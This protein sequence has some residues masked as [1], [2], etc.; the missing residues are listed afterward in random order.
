MSKKPIITIA[1]LSLILAACSGGD[2]SS[3]SSDGNFTQYDAGTHTVNGLTFTIPGQA[4][5]EVGADGTVTTDPA[6][7][8]EAPGEAAPYQ[9]ASGNEQFYFV[10]TDRFANG[11]TSNDFGGYDGDP[12]LSGFD[13]ANEGFYLGGDIRGLTDN[14]D[15]IEGLGTTAI[16]LTPPFK[17]KPVQGEGD[18][19]SAGYHGY[20][21]TDFTQIDPHYGTNDELQAFIDEAHSRD[22]KI[23]FDIITNHTADVITYEGGVFDYVPTTVEPYVDASGAEINTYELAGQEFP[24]LDPATSFPY[25]PVI[26]AEKVPGENTKVPDW[27]NDVTLYHNRGN[28]TWAGESVTYGDFDGL[29]DLMTENKVVVDG[30]AEIYQSWTDMGIDGFRI[31]TAKHVNFEF[32]ES[33]TKQIRDHAGGD[34]FMFGEVFDTN[35]SELARYPRNSDMDSV[36]DFAYQ[37][38]VVSYAN[39]G[40]AAGLSQLFADD[41]RYTT[42]D[43]SAGDLPTFLGNH[44]MGRAGYLLQGGQDVE[45]KFEL[46]YALLYLTRGQPVVY[47]GDEQGFVGSGGDKIARQPLFETDVVAYQDQKLLDGSTFGT[48]AHMSTN[49][50]EYALIVELSALRASHPALSDGPQVELLSS[51]DV[52][53]FSRI[54]PETQSEY[55][56]VVNSGAAADV[57]IPVLSD[58]GEASLL[59]STQSSATAPAS[60][61][62]PS[63]SIESS[64]I[65]VSAPALSA[66][67]YQTDGLV[68][69]TSAA[70]HIDALPSDEGM[71]DVRVEMERGYSEVAIYAH[72]V[73]TDEWQLLGSDVG[74]KARVFHDTSALP[75]D[76]I[77]EYAAVPKGGDVITATYVGGAEHP[78]ADAFDPTL[79]W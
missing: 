76:S 58:D 45:Q 18:A 78:V 10:M 42:A 12:R 75:A 38:A 43:S 74:P 60:S 37:A 46:A 36:L 79:S 2:T 7:S 22:I 73:G 35:V 29:D 26:G 25:V 33:F 51:G 65:A 31:D 48:G 34:F 52:Y 49:T 11:D 53:A 4:S 67:V 5:L 40:S 41:D 8:P 69:A 19:V 15:Y 44:D 77:I 21:V 55:I 56:V 39:G 1:A 61:S 66:T 17:N 20:W 30:M 6:S 63:I 64:R 54:D 24:E 16:W 14:L 9:S 47:Y 72:V 27:L 32:W 70:S 50:P 23:Y 59:W 3:E 68:P 28:S 13:P 57:E 71:I 62:E